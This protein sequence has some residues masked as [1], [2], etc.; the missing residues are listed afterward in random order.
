LGDRVPKTITKKGGKQKQKDA[1]CYLGIRP[2][3]PF[4]GAQ[5]GDRLAL[6]CVFPFRARPLPRFASAEAKKTERASERASATASQRS[7]DSSALEITFS[8][9]DL[10]FLFFC[11]FQGALKSFFLIFFFPRLDLVDLLTF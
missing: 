6:F 3:H 9:A 7:T 10:L 4:V 1:F 2:C 8:A 11:C 5:K